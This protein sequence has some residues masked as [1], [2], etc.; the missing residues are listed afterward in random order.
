VPSTFRNVTTDRV[1][2]PRRA[3]VGSIVTASPV[4]VAPDD[5]DGD[6]LRCISTLADLLAALADP[7]CLAEPG[8]VDL[9]ASLADQARERP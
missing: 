1:R 4:A 2:T 9:L 6:A 5:P 8:V 7:A 3:R